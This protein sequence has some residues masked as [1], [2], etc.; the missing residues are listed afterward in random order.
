MI[1][2]ELC[3]HRLVKAE[4]SVSGAYSSRREIVQPCAEKPSIFEAE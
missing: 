4:M 2:K 3:T 1:V